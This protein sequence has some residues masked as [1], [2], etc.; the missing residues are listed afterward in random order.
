MSALLTPLAPQGWTNER[1]GKKPM[2]K[3]F[4]S[5]LSKKNYDFTQGIMQQE[6]ECSL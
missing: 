1:N 5:S 4:I 3:C 2:K 6:E